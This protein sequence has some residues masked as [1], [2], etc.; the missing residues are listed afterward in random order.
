MTILCEYCGAEVKK[1]SLAKHHRTNKCKVFKTRNYHYNVIDGRCY[2]I[3]KS[4]DECVW[5]NYPIPYD[6]Y[7]VIDGRVYVT[8]NHDEN[9]CKTDPWD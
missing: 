9:E 4:P 2:L 3:D 6:I 5:N 8:T 7:E 1:S